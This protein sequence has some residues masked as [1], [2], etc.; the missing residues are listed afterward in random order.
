MMPRLLVPVALVLISGCL[1]NQRS[2]P[3]APNVDT[4]TAQADC[5]RLVA[6][7]AKMRTIVSDPA[8]R[9]SLNALCRRHYLNIR[10]F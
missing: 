3:A 1:H 10:V 8:R 5:T 7:S 9:D 4:K 6:D 2:R